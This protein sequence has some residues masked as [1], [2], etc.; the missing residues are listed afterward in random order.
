[1]ED[2]NIVM[3][4]ILGGEFPPN[5]LFR[6]LIKASECIRLQ[7]NHP[8]ICQ[9]SVHS[10]SKQMLGWFYLKSMKGSVFTS[11]WNAFARIDDEYV[12]EFESSDDHK[13]SVVWRVRGVDFRNSNIGSFSCD[14][15]LFRKIQHEMGFMNDDHFG[16]TQSIF[17]RR[18]SQLLLSLP[19]Q[20]LHK[21]LI[22]PMPATFML[23]NSYFFAQNKMIS[24]CQDVEFDDNV[25]S[26]L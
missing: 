11:L 1:M 24:F 13:I 4:F 14:W 2:S 18:M 5:K 16:L 9:F 26:T 23:F 22:V 6:S 15:N 21:Q 19:S 17:S 10:E 25:F 20:Q 7:H 3:R 12:L 8:R